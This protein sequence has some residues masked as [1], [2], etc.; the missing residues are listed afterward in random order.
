MEPTKALQEAMVLAV[1]WLIFAADW[2]A[3]K[4]NVLTTAQRL[5]VFG[6]TVIEPY[7]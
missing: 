7:G 5:D 4:A 6:V 2:S 3:E 1:N